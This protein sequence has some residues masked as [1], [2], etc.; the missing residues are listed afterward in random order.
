[1]NLPTTQ[2][3]KRVHRERYHH[4][5]L[6]TALINAAI[7]L[8][9]KNGPEHLSLRAAADQVGVSP[10]AVYH[11]F[12]DKDSLIDGVGEKLF[13]ELAGMQREVLHQI[14]GKSARAAKLRFRELG[15][16]YFSWAK[17]E[18]NLFR[19]VFGGFCKVKFDDEHERQESYATLTTCLDD[20]LR[21]GLISPSMRKHGELLTWSA[22]HGASYLIIEG[23]LPSEAFEDLLDA[24]E[25]A[26]K[27]EKGE[28]RE[29][30]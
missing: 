1:M 2:I 19:L 11:Y 12:P 29:L 4:G 23:L 17:N 30:S 13:T 22:V 14:P 15:R 21:T 25:L 10:S 16:T 7:E 27:G 26:L 6:R 3:F 8:V 28:K 18:P 5:D 20:L 24:I 9:R